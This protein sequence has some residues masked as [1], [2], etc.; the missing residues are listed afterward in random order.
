MEQQSKG[1]SPKTTVIT[2]TMHLKDEIMKVKE[3]LVG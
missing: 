3:K 1:E 2:N